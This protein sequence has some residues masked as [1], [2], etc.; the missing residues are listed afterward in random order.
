M[1]RISSLLAILLWANGCATLS[2]N[3]EYFYVCSYDTVWQAAIDSMKAYSIISQ[4]KD[5]GMIE[6]A[7]V[8]ME[9]KERSFGAFGRDVFGNR[10]RAR[11][12]VKVTRHDDVA[13]VSVVENRQRWHARGGI[14]SQATKWWPVDPSE[15]V[16][17]DVSGRLNS[18]LQEKGCSAS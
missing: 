11:L 15:E 18:K 17:Q 7:W 12:T 4:D 6:T 5:K 10:E 1:K 9:G 2:G 8:E 16:L 13:S 3:Q 14:T